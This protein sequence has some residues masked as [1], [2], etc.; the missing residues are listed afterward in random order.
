MMNTAECGINSEGKQ[1]LHMK[2]LQAN[3]INLPKSV[4]PII[5]STSVFSEVIVIIP[6][7]YLWINP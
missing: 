5:F 3:R 1:W 6:F 2:S 7:K 4:Q